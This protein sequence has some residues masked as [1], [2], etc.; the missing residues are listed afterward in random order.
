M[1]E[2]EP[3]INPSLY[4]N[5]KANPAEIVYEI[6]TNKN[7]LP[8]GIAIADIQQSEPHYHNVTIETY[9][10]VQGNLEVRLNT[11]SYILHPGD[12]IKILPGVTHS[13]KSLGE[14]PA[15]ITITTIPEFSQN[16]YYPVH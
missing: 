3:N 13:A 9:T 12:V 7:G 11:E 5:M 10:V 1:K 15:R 6:T 4:I 16:D 14:T 8:F 2:L